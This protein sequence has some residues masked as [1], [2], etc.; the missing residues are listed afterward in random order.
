MN[1]AAVINQ[2]RSMANELVLRESRGPGDMPNAMRRL[3]SKYGIP[4]ATF[5]HLRY[6]NP[7]RIWADVFLQLQA[8]YEMAREQQLR[9]LAH[10]I[11]VAKA[12]GVAADRI[13]AAEALVGTAN[14]E[15][16][17]K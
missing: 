13:R 17:G 15:G 10:E 2:A 16:E 5:F 3:E 6:R 1:S 14:S 9:K 11:E 7:K 8:A 12:R 4:A